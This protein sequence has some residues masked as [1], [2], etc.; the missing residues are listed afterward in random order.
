MID[1]LLYFSPSNGF[2]A[3]FL[4]FVGAIGGLG[5][6]WLLVRPGRRIAEANALRAE[7]AQAISPESL[8]D[9]YVSREQYDEVRTLISTSLEE[10]TKELDSA[11]QSIASLRGELAMSISSD[12]VAR[13]Y[14]ARAAFD[15]I[16]EELKR[17]QEELRERSEER[18]NL[19]ARVASVEAER[20]ALTQ[21]TTQMKLESEGLVAAS[22]D[23]FRALAQ[24]IF[25]EKARHFVDTN[26]AEMQMLLQ[27]LREHLTEFRDK[28]EATRRDE[29]QDITS[30]KE[31][32]VMLHQSSARL[33]E[34]ANQLARALKGGS[35]VQ[36]DWGEDRLRQILESEGLEQYIDFEEQGTYRAADGSLLR[37]DV[38]LKLPNN[39]RVVIDAKVSLRSYAEFFHA[40]EGADKMR[41]SKEHLQA[42]WNHVTALGAKEYHKAVGVSAFE[43]VLLFMPIEG[44]LTA[45]FRESPDLFQRALRHQV[46]LVSPS[47]LLV[48]LKVIRILWQREDQA[49]NVEL[50]VRECD[51][52]YSKFVDM[53]KALEGL[54]R[55]LDMAHREFALVKTR[56]CSETKRGGSIVGR[57][58]RI[59]SLGLV[60]STKEIP[61]S[62]REWGEVAEEIAGGENADSSQNG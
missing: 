39:R 20:E 47:T 49:R 54:E 57:I 11:H 37:P 15:E 33:S 4:L 30:L 31:Q 42:V 23:A 51:Q 41:H 13:Q 22:R 55:G 40:P 10:R 62:F 44:A 8:K 45:A 48:A 59:R 38:V 34:E 36:G 12:S 29:I 9:R 21:L 6:A 14:V 17:T 50:V 5:G 53:V 46:L 61:S 28:V 16:K 43:F 24:E 32:I 2:S 25:G 7:L 1:S 27:P 26:K 19:A 60:Q 52:L 18:T 3:A 35:R 58:E 56:L